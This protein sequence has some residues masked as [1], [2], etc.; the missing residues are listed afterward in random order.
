ML[1]QLV[2]R[3]QLGEERHFSCSLQQLQEGFDLLNTL[4]AK[5]HTLLKATINSPPYRLKSLK[6]F[7]S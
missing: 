5:G 4:V 3:D 7:R 6:A 2:A 1:L